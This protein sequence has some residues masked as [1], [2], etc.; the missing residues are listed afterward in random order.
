MRP[1]IPGG[2]N[3]TFCIDKTVQQ[4]NDSTHTRNR[5]AIQPGQTPPN[6]TLPFRV[7]GPHRYARVLRGIVE[8]QRHVP[9]LYELEHVTEQGGVHLE[10]AFVKPVGHHRQDVLQQP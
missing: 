8:L 4:Y 2:V 6:G 10:A 7:R 3:L 5:Y 1:T 9:G